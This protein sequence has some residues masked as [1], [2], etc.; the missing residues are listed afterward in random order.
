MVN[1]AR[2]LML[3][4]FSMCVCGWMCCYWFRDWK[5]RCRYGQHLGVC[6]S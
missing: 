1:F 2:H 5:C 4:G 6:C 3:Y